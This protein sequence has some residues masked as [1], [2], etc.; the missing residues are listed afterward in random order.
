M[1]ENWL[2]LCALLQILARASAQIGNGV[3]TSC[4]Q[5]V[6]CSQG[7][8]NPKATGVCY[9]CGP[10]WY[11]STTGSTPCLACPAN[12]GST[13]TLCT[14][15]AQCSCN[16][17]YSGQSGGNCTACAAGTYKSITGTTTCTACST[18]KYSATL[19]A[20]TCMECAT[21]KYKDTTGS[22]PCTDCPGGTF[23]YET[24]ST[25]CFACDENS[26]GL[27]AVGSSTAE[28]CIC[29][30]G[31]YYQPAFRTCLTCVSGTYKDI[32]NH[33]CT[34]CPEFSNSDNAAS[35]CTC[36]MG[37]TGPDSGT[38]TACP[39]GK[40]KDITGSVAC[41]DCPAGKYSAES[42][43][44]SATF[45]F[46][47]SQYTQGLTGA[48]STTSENCTCN[49]G[50]FWDS[51]DENCKFCQFGKYKNT[52]GNH[53]CA[54]CPEFTSSDM[55]GSS[56]TC[57]MGYTKSDSGT[58][59]AC[60]AGKYKDTTGNVACTDC[61]A[62]KYHY[63]ATSAAMTATVCYTCRHDTQ[64]LTPAGSTT[65]ENCIC[66]AGLFW[67]STKKYC[68]LCEGG[69]YKDIIGNQPCTNC[70][71]SSYSIDS[72]GSTSCVSCPTNAICTITGYVT[73]CNTLSACTCK[74]GYYGEPLNPMSGKPC[75]PCP[76]G[77]TCAQGVC[78]EEGHCWPGF[79]PCDAGYTGPDG[80]PCTPCATGKY[81]SAAGS[82]TCINC[83][84][85]K[86]SDAVGVSECIECASNSVNSEVGQ[87]SVHSCLCNSGYS[88]PT[89]GPCTISAPVALC[90]NNISDLRYCS[91]LTGLA[92]S[93]S[94]ADFEDFEDKWINLYKM[95]D[96]Y[97][98]NIK[99][100]LLQNTTR[101]RSL[102]EMYTCP[103]MASSNPRTWVCDS[104]GGP[105]L[106][107]SEMCAK[108]LSCVISN[109]TQYDE[110]LSQ[111]LLSTAKNGSQC[112]GTA[113]VLGMRLETTTSFS[114]S[115]APLTTPPST[116]VGATTTV[117]ATTTIAATTSV[118]VTTP[119]PV[120]TRRP[121]STTPQPTPYVVKMAVSLPLTRQEFNDIAQIT[122]KQS[123]A[124]A[125][126]VS[127][128]DVSIDRILDMND[129]GNVL[130]R[131]LTSSI[132]VDTSVQAPTESAASAISTSLTVETLN[133]ALTTAGLPAA[134][135]LE[136]PTF[137]SDRQM[138][139][140]PLSTPAVIVEP[141]S[142]PGSNLAAIIGGAV[143]GVVLC[144]CVLCFCMFYL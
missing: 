103:L 78:S 65:S 20:S 130:R 94:R 120:T 108:F 71:T 124:R 67:D 14:V 88:G 41:T 49:A 76:S 18:G 25:H 9:Q 70:P 53:A 22:G 17:G 16:V 63:S 136:A 33:A 100:G 68:V 13:C 142:E 1:R 132:R 113:G 75:T 102:F 118:P 64:G 4:P 43:A 79:T 35:A 2:M 117:A 126:G 61:P 84:R 109:F 131:L 97:T 6:L 137:A 58:C 36:D 86:Y 91:V 39:A 85:G 111:C 46:A 135:I 133:S 77:T 107:C 95:E 115:T 3:T 138:T 83:P 81:K 48:G 128:T 114:I 23:S 112:F 8:V 66:N 116:T 92:T 11:K 32:G 134:T 141:K 106:P 125:A 45:C 51:T 104:T 44:Y 28:G 30:A 123:V 96:T 50:R 52:I 5:Q 27:S 98:E 122:F 82:D 56:C 26:Q 90:Q 140:T 29:N 99:Q 55:A 143:G 129:G 119:V 10:G 101:C 69:K 60:P 54:S 37:Y 31:Y 72:S 89:G 80:G 127:S 47:C 24:S 15:S 121:P 19:G 34:L 62:G 40:Y 87:T 74:A 38:C 105:L 144:V 59:M 42:A 93:G 110:G 73:S 139:T 57:N 12:S 21:G 7:C